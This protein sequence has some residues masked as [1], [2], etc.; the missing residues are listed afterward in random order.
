MMS[1]TEQAILLVTEQQAVRDLVARLAN[2]AQAVPS[3]SSSLQVS[4]FDRCARSTSD[5]NTFGPL[6]MRSGERNIVITSHEDEQFTIETL[7]SGFAELRR[8]ELSGKA[9]A[10]LLSITNQAAGPKIS[11]I[12]GSSAKVQE[13]RK[14]LYRVASCSSNVLITGETGTGKELAAEMIHQQSDR[15]RKRFITLNCAAIPDG[16]IESELFGYERGSFTGAYGAKDGKLKLADGGTIFLDEI[17][18][19]SLYAQAKILRAI[20]GGEIQ[21]L[22]GR[23]SQR[24]NVRI[25]AA[26]NRN[27]EDDPNFRKDLFF[28]LNVARVHIPPLRERKEDILPL[29]NSFRTDLEAAFGCQTS[30]FTSCAQRLLMTHSWPGNIRELRNIIEA[31][32]VD[33]GPDSAGELELPAQFRE[34][35][36]ETGTSEL[37]RILLALSQTHWNKSRAAE[38]LKWSRMTLYRKIAH[39]KISCS[40]QHVSPQKMA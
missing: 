8:V 5:K 21:R 37:E 24:I 20:E 17:G 34:K 4:A 29:A 7:Q 25:I 22:G 19:L 28:R 9:F 23:Q 15:N 39:Y 35:L 26:T 10:Q 12:L 13:L 11:A 14:Y 27:L 3:C 36:K 2:D 16:L 33:P 18:D 31:A 32:F 40:P 38:E 6:S 1:R 30:S